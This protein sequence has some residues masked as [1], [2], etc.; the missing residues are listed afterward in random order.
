MWSWVSSVNVDKSST[1]LSPHPPSD[2][3]SWG[4][5]SDEADL[6]DGVDIHSSW[7]LCTV[8]D[9]LNSADVGSRAAVC[10]TVSTVL[11]RRTTMPGGQQLMIWEYVCR[12]MQHQIYPRLSLGTLINVLCI[13]GCDSFRPELV[14]V[15]TIWSDW[16]DCVG[17][18]GRYLGW[19]KHSWGEY[20]Q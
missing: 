7:S 6:V 12:V 13:V 8:S 3:I 20:I 10:T 11:M 17:T 2:P 19:G 18:V 5:R 14:E 4:C 1:L 16:L 15:G 9:L